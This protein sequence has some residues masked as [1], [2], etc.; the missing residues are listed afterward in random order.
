MP[1]HALEYQHEASL[2]LMNQ[3]KSAAL[4][5]QIFAITALLAA[6]AEGVRIVV[7][8][9][10]YLYDAV[11]LPVV[12]HVAGWIA[13]SAFAFVLALRVRQG[14][15]RSCAIALL[16]AWPL[17]LLLGAYAVLKALFLARL[18]RDGGLGFRRSVHVFGSLLIQ[19]SFLLAAIVLLGVA[20]RQLHVV[21]QTERK[22]S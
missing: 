12:I 1:S 2:V 22:L 4:W 6:C 10:L 14:G 3:R 8:I 19:F 11:L 15:R 13:I 16:G 5:L 20:L 9:Q 7:R 21:R 18:F 17:E